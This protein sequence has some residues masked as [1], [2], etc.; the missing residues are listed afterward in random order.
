M[1]GR[2][3]GRGRPLPAVVGVLMA[4]IPHSYIVA[5]QLLI[6]AACAIAVII[7]HFET[8]RRVRR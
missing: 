1:R 4:N 7:L 2:G 8:R 6:I 5:S 3:H